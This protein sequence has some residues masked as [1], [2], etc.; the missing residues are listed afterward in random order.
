MERAAERNIPDVAV[1][2]VSAVLGAFDAD[3]RELRLSEISRRCGLPKSTTSRLVAELVVYGFLERSGTLLHLGRRLSELGRLGV[4]RRDLRAVALPYLVDLR[5]ATRQSVQLA[6]LDGADVVPLEI[7]RGRNTPEPPASG[8]RLP[9]HACAPGKA[10]LACSDEAAVALVCARPL[11]A[12]GPRT[13]LTPESLRRQLSLVRESGLAYESE[14]SGPGVGGVACAILHADGRPVAAV[15]VTGWSGRLNPRAL[16]P[17]VRTVA[18][19]VGR[20]FCPSTS[21]HCRQC[22]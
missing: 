6:V 5:E 20:E 10:L 13:V 15:A 14:E 12:V 8:G 2:R 17:A 3:H 9:A 22:R 11:T 19:A 4:S 1:A 7:L 18:L 21:A 16:G